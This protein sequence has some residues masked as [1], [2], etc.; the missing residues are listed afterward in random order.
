MIA[1]TLAIVAAIAS[2]IS[3]RITRMQSEALDL[4]LR[5]NF[6]FIALLADRL[7]DDPAALALARKATTEM[8]TLTARHRHALRFL[9]WPWVNR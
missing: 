9:P 4:S 3:M 1:A 7:P 6:Q 5:L 2:F 8:Q